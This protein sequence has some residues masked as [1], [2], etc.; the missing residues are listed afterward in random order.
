MVLADYEVIEINN[1]TSSIKIKI[2]FKNIS[3]VSDG[4][5]LD[6]LEIIVHNSSIFFEPI[7]FKIAL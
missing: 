2:D 6:I 7:D 3:L 4:P 5:K 1:V